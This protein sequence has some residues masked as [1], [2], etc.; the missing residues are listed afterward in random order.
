MAPIPKHGR[1]QRT[2]EPY[3]ETNRPY[4]V[5]SYAEIQGSLRKMLV[6]NAKNITEIARIAESLVDTVR[7]VLQV[8]EAPPLDINSICSGAVDAGING[9]NLLVGFCPVVVAVGSI[10]RGVSM[11]GIPIAATTKLARIYEDEEEGRKLA[12]LVGFYLQFELGRRLIEEGIDLLIVDGPL[13]LSKAQYST[14][15]R[16]YSS[17]FII[18][19]EEA[20]RSLLSLLS[21]SRDAGVLTVGLVKRVRSSIMPRTLG[22]DSRLNDSV[23]ASIAMKPRE[24]TEP[25]PLPRDWSDIPAE[26]NW[27]GFFGKGL[28]PVAVFVKGNSKRVY[29]LEV[30]EYAVPKLDYIVRALTSLAD[31][32]SGLP[33]PLAHVDRLARIT[34]QASNSAYL[35]LFREVMLRLGPSAA[36]LLNIVTLQHGEV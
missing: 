24:Y 1:R 22:L 23:L 25:L 11:R 15:S 26:A 8:K 28:R 3:L 21:E 6:Q 16:K 19:Y 27:R 29:R 13:A 30:P 4:D 34:E 18:T 31:P 12:N 9:K 14:L 17:S 32:R 2:L 7:K 10:F 35:R 20:M 33:V 5:V 36:Q